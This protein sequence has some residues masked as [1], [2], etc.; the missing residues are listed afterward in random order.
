[1]EKK[2]KK[3]KADPV[4]FRLYGFYVLFLL[5][6]IFVVIRLFDI[7]I[8]FRPNQEIARLIAPSSQKEKIEPARGAILA[9][10]G[11]MLAMS[12]PIYDIHI[13]CTVQKAAFEKDAKQGAKKEAEWREKARQT[14]EGLAAIVGMKTADQYYK[15]IIDGRVSGKGKYVLLAKGIERKDYNKLLGLPLFVEGQN[16][17]GIIVSKSNVRMYPYGKLARR[18]IG[19]VRDNSSIRNTHVGIEG[20]YD[21]VLHGKEGSFWTRKVDANRKVQNNDSLYVKAEDGLDVRTTLNIDLQDILDKA[22]R[23][24]IDEDQDIEGGCA[25]IM[26]VKT[27]AIR[28][29]VN[30]LRDSL[31][32]RLEESQNL[33]IGRLGEPGSV[34][35]TS[36]LMTVLED[37][38]ISS[39]E[40]KIPTNHGMIGKF[41]RDEHISDYERAHKTKEISIIDGFKMSSN[42]VFRYLA[43]KNYTGKERN[44]LDKIYMYKLGE[45]FDFDL[46]G[47]ATPSVPSPDS[48]T[49]SGTDLGSV[50]IGYSISETPLHIIT[51]YNA[52]ANKG[53]MMRPYLVESVEKKG[54]VTEKC[55]PR[56]LNASICSKAVA[57]TLTRALKAVAEDGT[58]WRLKGAKCAVA[59]KTG[60]SRILL[61]GG[62]YEKYGLKKNQGTF[63]GFFPADDPKYSIIVT[64]YS[65]LSARNFY[66]GTYPASAVRAV[67][68]NI[69]CIDPTWGDRLAKTGSLPSM[70]DTLAV[71]ATAQG[72]A[73]QL[74]GLGLRDAMYII[75]NSGFKCSY[76]GVGHVCSQTPKAGSAMKKGETI[77]ITLK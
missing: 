54:L 46:E 48:K 8:N 67:V 10:D 66:G 35:K 60:T 57:D 36:T 55:G 40:D 65:K 34:F 21:Y 50:A 52:I 74:V 43:M 1:M 41:A 22:V 37:G 76:S 16:A 12:T 26:D 45:A 11:R 5:I 9:C 17:G 71:G 30:L 77:Q 51:F 18:T 39:L 62:T 32:N 14:S 44:F 13:D 4:G 3:V 2:K 73:P 42:Y 33:A 75:E 23:E 28:A 27:G 56:V 49:W 63:V 61:E 68:D 69:Y 38:K 25:I 53:K 47:L 58:A 70:K 7:Q 59:G 20:K 72:K 19:F 64:V 6:S 29:M 31:T 15:S 24:Q